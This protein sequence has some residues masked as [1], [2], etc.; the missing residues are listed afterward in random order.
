MLG[1]FVVT[2]HFLE[3]KSKE[4]MPVLPDASGRKHLPD[5]ALFSSQRIAFYDF[6][7]GNAAD[8]GSHLVRNGHSGNQSMRLGRGVQFSPGMGTKFS[9]LHPGDSSWIRITGFVWFTCKPADVACKLVATC[10][11][12]G[13]GFKYMS[14]AL[15]FENL[16]AGKWNKVALDYHI[17]P[18]PD[19]EDLVQA[20]F[21]YTGK[22]EILVDDIEI[23]YY[24]PLKKK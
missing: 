23:V 9:D 24:S 3:K 1:L 21:W 12:K 2:N 15:G 13:V 5:T 20:Y 6:E 22:A 10:N 8:I 19:G 17:P 14:I 18:A 11:H 7:S 16:R 4:M